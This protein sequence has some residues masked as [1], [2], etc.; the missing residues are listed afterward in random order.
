M[1]F[2]FLVIFGVGLALLA[3]TFILG[4]IFDFGDHGDL[5]ADPSPLSSRVI[6]VFATAFGGCGFIGTALDWP[7]WASALLAVGGGL[8][9][10]GGT[11]FLIVLPISRQQGSTDVHEA[12]FTGLQG[13][14]TSEIP[15]G[16]LGRVTVIAPTSKARIGLPARS[17]DG[18]RI[19]FGATVRIAASSESKR[20]RAT[21]S[22]F[23]WT[24]SFEYAPLMGRLVSK[25]ARDM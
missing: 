3:V 23:T 20:T 18:Q 7:A 24:P 21:A 16:G 1:Q 19:P 25:G 5:G 8:G 22:T 17:A 4:E 15:E 2:A 14:V 6:F 11:F 12:D 10:A 13:Q 9:V